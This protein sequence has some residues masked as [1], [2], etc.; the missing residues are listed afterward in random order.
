MK[1]SSK[2]PTIP[3]ALKDGRSIGH[4]LRA[5]PGKVK[6]VALLPDRNSKGHDRHILTGPKGHDKYVLTGPTVIKVGKKGK[7]I[8]INALQIADGLD[9]VNT[10]KKA[11][12]GISGATRD[13]VIIVE[14]AG[15]PDSF[16]M[17][18]LDKALSKIGS[19]S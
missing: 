4:L 14:P 13:G 17:T 1:K 3:P 6:H 2:A 18:Q 7:R 11:G 10:Y 5:T 12:Y 8:R 9:I 15:Q 16:D 19:R